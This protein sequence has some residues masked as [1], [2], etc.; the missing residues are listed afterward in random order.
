MPTL[1]GIPRM[2]LGITMYS[3]EHTSKGGKLGEPLDVGPGSARPLQP[4]SF[5]C[6]EHRQNPRSS[7]N[8]SR[9]HQNLFPSSQIPAP[10]N[11]NERGTKKYKATVAGCG[12]E[13]LYS[14]QPQLSSRSNFETHEHD[15]I[16]HRMRRNSTPRDREKK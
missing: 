10:T 4:A 13:F 7:P 9:E 15:H 16:R 14:K 12:E 2:R 11:S 6:S 1:K 8:L 5:N 3:T